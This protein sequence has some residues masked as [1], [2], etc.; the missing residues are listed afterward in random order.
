MRL[1]NIFILFIGL[2]VTHLAFA[3][4]W[5]KGIY[6]TQSTAEN[7][8]KLRSF[9]Q[10]AKANGINTFVIDVNRRSNAY[11]KN[12]QL[13]NNSGINYVARVVLF[14]DGGVK[15]QVLSKAYWEKK[16]ALVEYATLLGADAIQLDY[17]RYK[18][19]QYPSAQ[20][21]RDIY[22][23]IKWFKN[24]LAY[25]GVPLQIDVFGIATIKPSNYIGHNLPLF[26]DS[27]DAMCPMVY[28]S[29]YAPY[30][31]NSKDPY[32]AVSSM[33]AAMHD[34]FGGVHNFKIYPFI[35]V[36]NFRYPLGGKAQLNYIHQEIKAVED[37]SVNGWYFWSPNNQYAPLYATLRSYNVR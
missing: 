30:A 37:G 17:V 34:Q 6:L 12:I 2:F 18:P 29:H 5:I 28:P 33:L 4:T 23:V 8:A 13:V 16:Y 25:K 11:S 27:V 9:I 3:D 36:Y 26:A 1:K 10:N 31:Q 22:E 20:N 15:S 14:P 21:A 32:G 24:R 35:E 7:T 19:S